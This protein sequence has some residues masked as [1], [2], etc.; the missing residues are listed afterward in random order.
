MAIIT[1][2]MA[3]FSIFGY[4]WAIKPSQFF[5]M[6]EISASI[7]QEAC[8]DRPKIPKN[9]KNGHSQCYTGHLGPFSSFSPDYDLDTCFSDQQGLTKST[10]VL[11]FKDNWILTLNILKNWGNDHNMHQNGHIWK[12]LVIFVAGTIQPISERA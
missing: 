5:Q 10:L 8:T 1:L 11:I 4:F 6:G 12:F 7:R 3:I 2:R 9:W